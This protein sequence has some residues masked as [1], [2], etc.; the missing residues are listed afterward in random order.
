MFVATEALGLLRSMVARSGQD[1]APWRRACA[2]T[3]APP[4]RASTG[5]LRGGG[6]GGGGSD[7]GVAERA[8]DGPAAAEVASRRGSAERAAE[9]RLE[10]CGRSGCLARTAD[11]GPD[12]ARTCARD[13]TAGRCSPAA[14]AV[15]VGGSPEGEA[16]VEDLTSV[17]RRLRP[18]DKLKHTDLEPTC[19][20]RAM[21]VEH[22]TAAEQ[23]EPSI[24]ERD[25]RSMPRWERG[26][27]KRGRRARER[28]PGLHPEPRAYGRRGPPP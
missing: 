6:G 20:R 18:G 4:S 12:R 11:T 3:F 16:S 25:A 24:R 13:T 7:R 19:Q 17:P 14:V 5:W 2:G 21:Q 9:G 22:R 8:A 26:D 10:R 23:E 27:V 15:A 28:R 1:G